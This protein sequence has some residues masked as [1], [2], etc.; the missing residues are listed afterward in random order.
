[1]TSIIKLCAVLV[2]INGI[3]HLLVIAFYDKQSSFWLLI[4][5]GILYSILG[6]IVWIK[7]RKPLMFTA[8]IMIVAIPVASLLIKRL[9]YP[10][11]LLALFIAIDLIV[12]ILTGIVYKRWR[13]GQS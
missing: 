8:C 7:G 2:L 6:L 9:G 13:N 1:M 4:L 3:G 12:V 11:M 10:T 5:F